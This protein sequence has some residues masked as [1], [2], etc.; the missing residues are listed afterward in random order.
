M[1]TRHHVADDRGAQ[2]TH[3]HLLGHVHAAQVDHHRVLQRCGGDAKRRAIHRGQQ[4]SKRVG[5]QP[6]I[7]EAR[8][9]DLGPLGQIAQFNRLLDALRQFARV[10]SGGLRQRQSR[11]ALE[12]AVLGVGTRL[13]LWIDA[14]GIGPRHLGD[15]GAEGLFKQ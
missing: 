2:V 3:V 4:L 5:A 1:Q 12:V 9:R 8:A 7:D 6:H 13:H 11:V 15:A 14:G 10:A